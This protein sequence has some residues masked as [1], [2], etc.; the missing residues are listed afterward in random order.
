MIIKFIPYLLGALAVAM[1]F[2]GR[3]CEPEPRPIIK[4]E[5][6]VKEVRRTDTVTVEVH[7]HHK[8]Y[9]AIASPSLLTES[10]A[11]L[12]TTVK[13]DSMEAFLHTEYN[14]DSSRFE[15][16]MMAFTAKPQIKVLKEYVD[17]ELIITNTVEVE[18]PDTDD[19]TW[20]G[21]GSIIGILITIIGAI[22]L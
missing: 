10:R 18:K 19:W 4:P 12:D 1:F 7:V 2:L 13:R 5:V 6:T 3:G 14:L 15:N 20:G 22:A 21:I 16:T 11:I 8:E 9:I 17:R